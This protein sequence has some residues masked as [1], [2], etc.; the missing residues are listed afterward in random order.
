MEDGE[1]F[2]PPAEWG[3]LPLFERLVRNG[4]CSYMDL[5]RPGLTAK[6]IY[7][8]CRMLDM[9]EYRRIESAVRSRP[10]R[11][12]DIDHLEDMLNDDY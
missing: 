8:M 10:N 12:M 3:D 1:A 6:D 2:A 11:E 7:D 4:L 5:L 9:P